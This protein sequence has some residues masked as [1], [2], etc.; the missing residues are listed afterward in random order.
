VNLGAG[1]SRWDKAEFNV[2]YK[3]NTIES[4]NH[5]VKI[6]NHAFYISFFLFYLL[7]FIYFLGKENKKVCVIMYVSLLYVG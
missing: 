6:N 1:V 2:Y 3:H 4:K 5:M 7:F